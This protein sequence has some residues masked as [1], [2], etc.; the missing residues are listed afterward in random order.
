MRGLSKEAQSEFERDETHDAGGQEHASRADRE[1]VP[2][3]R[4]PVEAA[5]RVISRSTRE[6][7]EADVLR[8]PRRSP[9]ITGGGGNMTGGPPAPAPADPR[10][11]E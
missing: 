3:D 8:K 7:S 5:T 4:R 10:D 6:Q 9:P 11:D 1:G 2:A